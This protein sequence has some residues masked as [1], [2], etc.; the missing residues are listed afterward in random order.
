MLAGESFCLNEVVKEKEERIFAELLKVIEPKIEEGGTS[1]SLEEF[2]D[3][4]LDKG[5]SV[6]SRNIP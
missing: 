6:T 2:F 3:K 5:F 4:I 1:L